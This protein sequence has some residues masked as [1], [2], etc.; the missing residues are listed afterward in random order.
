M[1]DMVNC[2][3]PTLT[4]CDESCNEGPNKG[5]PKGFAFIEME[6]LESAAAA[7]RSLNGLVV[8]LSMNTLI[9]LNTCIYIVH[10][11]ECIQTYI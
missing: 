4:S 7:I 2:T 6:D 3:C 5:L 9:L 11:F 1:N 8:N 10:T